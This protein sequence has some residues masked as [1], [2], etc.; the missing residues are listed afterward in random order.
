L[1]QPQLLG[2]ST[3]LVPSLFFGVFVELDQV[4]AVG[5]ADQPKE[6]LLARKGGVANRPASSVN[7]EKGFVGFRDV[8]H[9]RTSFAPGPDL[10]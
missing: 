5:A 8:V 3:S 10:R 9:G 4:T 1:N 6:A 7:A 2:L